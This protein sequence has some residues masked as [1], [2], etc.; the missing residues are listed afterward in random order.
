M[1]LFGGFQERREKKA[2]DH[3]FATPSI[4]ATEIE[5]LRK[6]C[7]Q[8]AAVLHDT[9]KNSPDRDRR[10]RALLGLHSLGITPEMVPAVLDALHDEDDFVQESAAKVLGGSRQSADVVVP[11]LVA[12]YREKASA[13]PIVLQIFGEYGPEARAAV[14]ALLDG[15]ARPTEALGVARCLAKIAPGG[16][17]PA[18][19]AMVDVLS[20]HKKADELQRVPGFQSILES[21]LLSCAPW[22]TVDAIPAWRRVL[23]A[24]AAMCER[25]SEPV[26]RV[27]TELVQ[28]SDWKLRGEVG[29]QFMEMSRA[30]IIAKKLVRPEAPPTRA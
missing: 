23:E 4:D 29:A 22:R 18:A 9:L 19:Q 5:E 28:Y 17:E 11:A 7:P 12:F 21:F 1:A 15:L 25:P 2:L 26:L 8:A 10:F 20:E 24:Y 6:A 27:L 16:L 13:R 3:Y 30:K 14:P